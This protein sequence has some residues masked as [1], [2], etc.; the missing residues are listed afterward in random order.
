MIT[1]TL[2][3]STVYGLQL[4][5]IYKR[6]E[7]LPDR[8]HSTNLRMSYTP[9]A[10]SNLS[11]VPADHLSSDNYHNEEGKLMN[12][13]RYRP[14]VAGTSAGPDHRHSDQPVKVIPGEFYTTEVL[15]GE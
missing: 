4:P 12:S 5:V 13:S 9:S 8:L 1:P 15:N 10:L 7:L 14:F 11:H 6:G 2:S 3:V